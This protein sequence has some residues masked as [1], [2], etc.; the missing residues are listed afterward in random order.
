MA[1]YHDKARAQRPPLRVPQWAFTEW[2]SHRTSLLATLKE[3]AVNLL[4]T[5]ASILNNSHHFH[6]WLIWAKEDFSNGNFKYILV[7][8]LDF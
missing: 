4:K 7:T 5:G 3:R 8:E 2:F 1:G 6:C